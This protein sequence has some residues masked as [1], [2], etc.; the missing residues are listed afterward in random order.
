[1]CFPNLRTRISRSPCSPWSLLPDSDH[2]HRHHAPLPVQGER[3]R[4][5]VQRGRHAHITAVD[6][7]GVQQ[8]EH[9]RRRL[10][11][12]LRGQA[13]KLLEPLVVEDLGYG[14][15]I[16]LNREKNIVMKAADYANL[17]QYAGQDLVLTDGT[18]LLPPRG[19]S[20]DVRE[21]S[22]FLNTGLNLFNTN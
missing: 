16:L 3:L 6:R 5:R 2:Q 9:V 1:M 14:G 15:D 21:F 18:T 12:V 19:Y 8:R 10:Q 4:Q 22:N 17:R 7:P 20:L 11:G 13:Q